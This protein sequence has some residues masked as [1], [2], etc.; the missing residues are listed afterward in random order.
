MDRPASLRSKGL[1]KVAVIGPLADAAND[2]EGGW[3]VEGLFGGGSK[4]HPVTVLNG[5]K[6]KLSA[7]AQVILVTGAQPSKDHSPRNIGA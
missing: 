5:I 3:A 2:I 1:K 7:D 6:N 4:S